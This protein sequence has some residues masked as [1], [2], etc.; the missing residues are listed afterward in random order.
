MVP[1]NKHIWLNQT[2]YPDNYLVLP[3][4]Y[5]G[6]FLSIDN[7]PKFKIR[8]RK[9]I[10]GSFLHSLGFSIFFNYFFI[11]NFIF[12]FRCDLPV[13]WGIATKFMSG[14]EHT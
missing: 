1:D 9:H 10:F 2:T 14:A 3:G 5:F 6:N 12:Q 11:I 4:M 8:T 7:K 13:F